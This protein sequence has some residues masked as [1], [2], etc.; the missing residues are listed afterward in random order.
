MTIDRAISICQTAYD[1]GMFLPLT[2]GLGEAVRVVVE[3]YKALSAQL[4]EIYQYALETQEAT[5]NAELLDVMW[6]IR[7]MA[8]GTEPCGRGN[9]GGPGEEA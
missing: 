3:G 2:P 9:S 5:V 6:S 4:Q 1:G 7:A 8:R